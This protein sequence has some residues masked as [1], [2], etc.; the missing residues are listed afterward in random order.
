MAEYRSGN[1][2]RA[3][4]HFTTVVEYDPEGK[5]MG[6][7]ARLFRSM[8]RHQ[9]GRHD[10]AQADLKAV[11]ERILPLPPRDEL[12]FTHDAAPVFVSLVYEEAKS[13]AG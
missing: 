12:P 11:E 6:N 8:A 7:I 3:E 13:P 10:E 2:A 5:Q 4:E 1:Y 9:L